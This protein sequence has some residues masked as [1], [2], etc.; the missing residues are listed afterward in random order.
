LSIQERKLEHDIKK[1]ALSETKDIRKELFA[2]KNAAMD[3]L[4]NIREMEDLEQEGL[5]GAG[6][7]K[8]LED[9]GLDIPALLGAPAEQ[10]NK[11]AA[12]FVKNAKAQFGNRLTDT[13]LKE[14]LKQ[15]PSLS[16]SP[17]G[18]KRINATLKRMANLEIASA[19][20][21]EDI[22]TKNGG[23]PPLDLDLQLSKALDKK[24][25]GVYKQFKKDL[26]KEVPAGE[27]SLTT[28]LLSSA[29]KIA[30]KIPGA[31][32]GG[33]EGAALGAYAGSKGGPITALGGAGLGA[34]SGLLGYTP[35]SSI[36][37]LL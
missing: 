6:Y 14:F 18:R 15:V 1:E 11:I 12:T 16:N 4:E 27:S 8:L 30:G 20:A 31:I 21:Y 35:S 10:Y 5:P 7:V 32:K 2:K 22:V 23:I 36:K 9:F 25:E 37:S 34:L 17:E 29:G 3:M 26:A 28:A 24:R 33:L 13:D 19:E